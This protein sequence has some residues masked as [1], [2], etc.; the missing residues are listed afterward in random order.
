[1]QN[2]VTSE[3]LLRTRY[4]VSNKDLV[5]RSATFGGNSASV[6]RVAQFA[7]LLIFDS[8]IYFGYDACWVM[9]YEHRWLMNS[10]NEKLNLKFVSALAKKGLGFD[11]RQDLIDW[12]TSRT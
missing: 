11:Y 7:R 12:A 6:D 3:E 4:G 2:Q 1:M 5:S 8:D 10:M 9:C